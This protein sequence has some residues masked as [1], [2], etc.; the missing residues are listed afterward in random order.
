MPQFNGNNYDYWDITMK[1]LFNSQ[2]IWDLVDSG[3]QEPANVTTYNALSQAERDLLRDNKKKDA[4]FLFFIFQTVHE[5]IFPRVATTKSKQA[6]DT[7]QTTYQGMAKTLEERRIVEKFLRSL[8]VRFDAIVVAIEETNDLSQFSVD[9]LHASLI[10]HEHR[11]NRATS[12]SL[13]HAFKTQ[14]SFG[15]GRGRGRSYARGR[16]RS[17]HRGGR[18]STSSSSGRETIKIQVIAQAKIKHKVRGM[19]NLKPNVITVRS[20]V[21]MQMNVESNNMTLVTNQV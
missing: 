6:W 1:A 8:P 2:D 13:E 21:I 15:Q 4:K 11:I 18:S 7:L 16:G 20:M 3:F 12:S 10:S 14:V 5:S 19:I 9:E 17:T